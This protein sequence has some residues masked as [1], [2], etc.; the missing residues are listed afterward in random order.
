MPLR[1]NPAIRV[2]DVIMANVIQPNNADVF[3]YT[4]TNDFYLNGIQ[5]YPNDKK[6]EIIN[7]NIF[8]I[9]D[10]ISFLEPKDAAHVIEKE[11][12]NF[13]G[14]F[15]KKMVV[16][17]PIDI[18]QD[19]KYKI[20]QECDNTSI[21]MPEMM[22]HQ[23][24]K[25]KKCYDL[26]C[27]Y[28]K[29]NGLYDVVI[30][31][32]FDLFIEPL[33]YIPSYDLT[34]VDLYIPYIRGPTVPDWCAIGNRFS[35][36]LYMSIYD[37]LGFTLKYGKTYVCEC[38]VC[39]ECL[40]YGPDAS[41]EIMGAQKC[42]RCQRSDKLWFGDISIG[43]EYHIFRT[44]TENKLR[45]KSIERLIYIYRYKEVT[46][47]SITPELLKSLNIDNAILLNHTGDRNISTT[48]I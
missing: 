4:D 9:Y 11:I 6:I 8:R 34:N 45:F 28:E 2:C 39:G 37:N 27:D 36:G 26:I 40:K 47:Q 7:G 15:L 20:L 44:I 24:R 25:I 19:P 38:S 13:L 31:G 35:M 32:R 17:Y 21:C 23:Y 29:I 43:P 12:T 1:E 16:E 14:G 5:Y 42:P 41:P 48:K 22:T 33:V 46:H 18:K 30:K 3:I 10:K